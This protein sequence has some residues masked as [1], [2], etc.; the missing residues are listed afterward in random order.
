MR[1]DVLELSRFSNFSLS[2][3]C[4]V[5]SLSLRRADC[6][7]TARWEGPARSATWL[8]LGVASFAP[9]S[10]VVKS[11]FGFPP[12]PAPLP[13][14]WRFSKVSPSR[15][16]CFGDL[17]CFSFPFGKFAFF[18]LVPVG[19]RR[20]QAPTTRCSQETRRCSLSPAPKHLVY[21]FFESFVNQC[22]LSFAKRVLWIHIQPFP[23]LCAVF[24][25]HALETPCAAS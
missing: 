21:S 8:F 1:S 9:F 10:V 12:R 7:R 17:L 24:S 4:L 20:G 25:P 13:C 23:K 22:S 3:S 15:Q 18:P 16:H 5:F 11:S 14:L 6:V 2:W 19:A